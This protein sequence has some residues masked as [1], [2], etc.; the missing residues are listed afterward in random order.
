MKNWFEN[1]NIFISQS[2]ATKWG[3]LILFISA[4]ADASILPLP[5]TTYFLI[6]ILLNTRMIY[7]NILFAVVGTVAGAIAGY[8]IGHYAW[9]KPDGD[10]TDIVQF[11]FKNI[12]GFSVTAYE[13][14]HILYSK[15]NFWILG[16]ATA[17]PLPYGVFSVS[18]GV[19]NLNI[20]IFFLVTFICQSIKYFFLAIFA[21]VL[22]PKIKLLMQSEL[23]RIIV[24]ATA[25]IIIAIILSNSL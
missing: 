4:F 1:F 2:A 12:P 20:F 17:T 18:A 10:F 8:S 22:G 21:T 23:K 16:L 5:V 6:L 13:N 14:V 25:F 19:F 9:V 24:I 7:K 15:W 3:T 11:L